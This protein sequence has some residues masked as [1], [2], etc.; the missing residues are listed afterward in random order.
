MKPIAGLVFPRDR[1]IGVSYGIAKQVSQ[2]RRWRFNVNYYYL[3]N[4]P[5]DSE[6]TPLSG[7]IVGSYD[8]K[9]AI[10][11]NLNYRWTF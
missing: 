4:A 8:K 6:P 9:H 2:E 11:F 3:G 1:I 7:R 5:I 10:G